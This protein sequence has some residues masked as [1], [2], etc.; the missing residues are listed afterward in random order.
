MQVENTELPPAMQVL[1]LATASWM[2][3][4]VS[5]AAELGVADHLG[6][7]ARTVKDLADAV[8]A[9]EQTLYRL[10]RACADVG[11]FQELARPHLRPHR[12]RRGAAQRFAALAAQLRPLGGPAGRPAHLGRPGA[13][14]PHR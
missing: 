12:G 6:S 14:R 3:S 9:H 10:L 2:A 8:G 4:A 7:G 1:K 11:L 13:D 5:A